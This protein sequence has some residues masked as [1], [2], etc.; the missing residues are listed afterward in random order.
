MNL[1]EIYEILLRH[2]GKQYWWPGETKFEI[3]IGA[4]LTQQ[5]SW[6]NVEKAIRNLKKKNLL[7]EASLHKTNTKKIEDAIKPSGFYRI[8]TR[9]L[10]NFLDYLFEKYDGNLRKLLNLDKETLRRELLSINGIGKE[11]ADS[12][13]LYAA[14]KPVFVVDAYTHRIFNRI[15]IIDWTEY[16]KTRNFLEKKLEKNVELC[17]EFHALIVQL[18]KNICKPKP[19]CDMCP[20]NRGC[21]YAISINDSAKR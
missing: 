21:K 8:K 17:K 12:I 19:K 3:V 11:T 18:G 13:I 15:G 9:R 10:K 7:N 5:T 14:E 1:R 6:R 20:L 4:I 16:E 2:F